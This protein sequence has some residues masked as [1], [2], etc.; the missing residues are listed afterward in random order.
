MSVASQS[1]FS[2]ALRAGT[3]GILT[4][5]ACLAFVVYQAMANPAQ[6]GWL[7]F[8]APLV[9]LGTMMA[10]LAHFGF[11]LKSVDSLGWFA[12]ASFLGCLRCAC[13]SLS[14]RWRWLGHN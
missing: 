10:M 14:T 9:C 7:V 12:A 2:P 5:V 11:K 6:G 4:C 3:L 13:W 8:S 1:S